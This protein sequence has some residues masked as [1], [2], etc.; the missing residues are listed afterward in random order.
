MSDD[1]LRCRELE[2][3]LKSATA[4]YR[5]AL[6]VV[7][8]AKRIHGVIEWRDRDNA[9]NGMIVGAFAD[10]ARLADALDVFDGTRV[11]PMMAMRHVDGD[12]LNNEPSNI[13]VYPLD[14]SVD[15]EHT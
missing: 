11:P 12:P 15:K 14:N 5:K 4:S 2:A 6:D 13:S 1:C 10:V 9:V 8:A 7:N 3:D